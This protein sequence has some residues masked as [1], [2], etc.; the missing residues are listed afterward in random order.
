MSCVDD[1]S[2][3]VAQMQSTADPFP[4]GAE[5]QATSAAGEIERLRFMFRQIF[6]LTQWYRHDQA[7]TFSVSHI[8]IQAL[9]LSSSGVPGGTNNQQNAF[10]ARFPV[11]TGPDHWTGIWWPHNT[12]HMA[13]SFRDYNH[14]QGGVQGGIELFRWHAGGVTFHHTVAL[15]FKHSESGMHGGQRGH[16]TALSIDPTTDQL[17]L[18]HPGA[19]MRVNGT[20]ITGQGGTHSR[21]LLLSSAGHVYVTTVSAGLQSVQVFAGSG[22]WTRP[23]GIRRV[24]IEVVGGGGG[25][26][27]TDAATNRHGSG[28]GGGGYASKLLVVSSIASSTIT[29]GGGG[30]GGAAGANDGAAGVASSWAD[31][32]NTVTGNGGAGGFST[33]TPNSVALGGTATGG[34]INIPGGESV[35]ASQTAGANVAS[36]GGSSRLGLGAGSTGLNQAAR[37][38]G[39]YGGGGSGANN[40]D[41]TARAGGNG[42]AG[43]VIVWEYQ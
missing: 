6:G 43:I 27:G 24:M 31:G 13:F 38:G 19:T 16:V 4:S 41:A 40:A 21:A 29:V 32:T 3:T 36:G 7:P 5:S 23:A 20:G 18:G 30:T 22:T 37:T 9:H 33:G 2:A 35:G 42:A 10:L 11:L 39:V 34:D 26:G 28:G 8:S 15:M 14:A 1:F 25:G 12:A 17:L